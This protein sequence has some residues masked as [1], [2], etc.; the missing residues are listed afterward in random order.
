MLFL[1]WMAEGIVITSR[2]W[3]KLKMVLIRPAFGKHGSHFIFDPNSFYS[4]KNIEVGDDVSIGGGAVFL[5]AKS[6]ITIGNKVMFGPNVT[7]VGGRHNTSIVGRFMYDVHEKRSDDDLGV[8]I[9]DDVWVG[10]GAIILR[11]VRVGRGSIIA[12]G[13]VVTKDVL[14]YAIVGGNP[15]KVISLRFG[16]IEAISKHDALLYP[17]EKRLNT[18]ILD[19]ISSYLSSRTTIAR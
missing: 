6:K 19:E 5:A 12:A 11:G 9:E 13:A 18:D 7:V 4:Y 16:D 15:A 3:L 8:I 10:S 14:P 2:L 1:H 17:I